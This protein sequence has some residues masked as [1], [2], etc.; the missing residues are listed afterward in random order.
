MSISGEAILKRA[1]LIRNNELIYVGI[2]VP[3]VFPAPRAPKVQMLR[4]IAHV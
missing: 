3:V 2:T 4:K 1:S